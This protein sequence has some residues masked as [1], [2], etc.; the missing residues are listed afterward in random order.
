M[1]KV[2]LKEL[3]T[4]YQIISFGQVPLLLIQI[5]LSKVVSTML[6]TA[7]FVKNA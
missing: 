4:Q 2:Y 6:D 7:S 5:M 1:Q 3:I